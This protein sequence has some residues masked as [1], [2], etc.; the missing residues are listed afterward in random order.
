MGEDKS[1]PRENRIKSGKLQ[2]TAE[3]ILCFLVAKAK[4]EN[5]SY[6]HDSVTTVW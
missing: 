1:D 4:I 5:I 2:V 6:S 3:M